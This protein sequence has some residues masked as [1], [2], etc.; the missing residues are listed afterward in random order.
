AD[1]RSYLPE[2]PDFGSPIT[3]RHLL[4]H[5]SGYRDYLALMSLAGKRDEDYYDDADLYR[6][7]S[8]QEDLNFAPGDDHLY[9]NSGYFLLSQLVLRVTGRSLAEVARER[10]FEPLGMDATHYHDNWRRVVPNRAVGYAPAAW[11]RPGDDGPERRDDAWPGYV[12]GAWAHGRDP[13]DGSDWVVDVTTLPM[14]G[15][16]GVFSSVEEMA[17][18]VASLMTPNEVLGGKPWLELMRSRGVLNSGDTL[19]YALGLVHGEQRGLRTL[20]HGGAFVGY[21]AAV[22]TWPDESTGVV[23]LCNRADGRPGPLGQA[24]GAIVL[25]DVMEPEEVATSAGDTSPVAASGSAPATVRLTAAQ[26]S[27]L[28]GAYYSPELDAVWEI[29]DRGDELHLSVAGRERG[30][31]GAVSPERLMG[32]GVEIDVRMGPQGRAAGLEVD[33]GRVR[34][35]RFRRR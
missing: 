29:R 6:L 5:T 9:S 14:I 22:M 10:I 15:D 27:A 12:A 33:A 35:L 26:R 30:V 24:V 18:W 20:G 11:Y 4:H 16:G 31:L 19:D 7:L 28:V 13:F 32:D 17:P 21:R 2:L 34:N 8:A 25:A 3:A 1:I 23:T